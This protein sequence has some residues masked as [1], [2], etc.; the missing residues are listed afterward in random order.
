MKRLH[1][2]TRTATFIEGTSVILKMSQD[3]RACLFFQWTESKAAVDTTVR[4][5]AQKFPLP[6]LWT[7]IRRSVCAVD[8]AL[9][10]LSSLFIG[11]KSP[12][13]SAYAISTG[14]LARWCSC[15]I[16]FWNCSNFP[17]LDLSRENLRNSAPYCEKK[18]YRIRL[19]VLKAVEMLSC[20]KNCLHISW[21]YLDI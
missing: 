3:C 19:Q 17:G 1:L 11:R 21:T 20:V 5:T 2:K 18:W 9:Q 16:N 7:K 12:W 8:T 6:G 10:K 4:I 13:T 15:R 14:V